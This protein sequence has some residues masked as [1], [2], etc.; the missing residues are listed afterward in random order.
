MTEHTEPASPQQVLDFWFGAPGSPEYGT[1]RSVWFTKS[2]AFDDEIRGRFGATIEA[3]LGGACGAWADEQAPVAH[4]LALIVLLDQFTRN[5]FRNSARMVAGD[6]IAL[7]VAQDLVARGA[8][9]RL[10]PIQRWF[11]YLPYEHAEDLRIQYRSL[12]LFADLAGESGMGDVFEWARKHQ[13]IIAR[14]GRFPHRNELLGRPSS[15]AEVEFLKG[16]DSSF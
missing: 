4:H 5:V 1:R 9:R 11:C 7:K 14:F 15:A 3:A 2:D 6:P 12:A 13:V 8:D 10:A 16:P